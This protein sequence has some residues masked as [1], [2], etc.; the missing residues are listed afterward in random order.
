MR[1][2]VLTR[3]L[4]AGALSVQVDGYVPNTPTVLPATRKNGAQTGLHSSYTPFDAED[5]VVGRRRA[6]QSILGGA[7]ACAFILPKI[8][9]AL[10]MDA[11]A[12]A[13]V[14]HITQN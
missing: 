2:T 5:N 14:N 6:F 10:D 13:E 1:S 9:N 8:A 4:T 7:A 11:F 12:N 3:L